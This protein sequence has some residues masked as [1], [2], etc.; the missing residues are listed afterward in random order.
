M[1]MRSRPP[2][3]RRSR[4]PAARVRSSTSPEPVGAWLLRGPRRAR[5]ADR[6]GPRGRRHRRAARAALPAAVHNA[7]VDPRVD[8][9]R[10][11]VARLARRRPGRELERAV[12]AG[13]DAR[14]VA[15][16]AL[17][18][19]PQRRLPTAAPRR[20]ELHPD[21]GGAMCGFVLEPLRAAVVAVLADLGD[22]LPAPVLAVAG[23]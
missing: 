12:R 16:Q 19:V 9:R 5:T 23:G 11:A 13:E 21:T 22:D 14:P 7:G 17:E 18:G 2:L 3:G 10:V 15:P 1:R 6:R 4:K 8:V 20:E